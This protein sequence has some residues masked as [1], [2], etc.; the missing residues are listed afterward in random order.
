MFLSAEHIIRAYNLFFISYYVS[1]KKSSIHVQT[2][3]FYWIVFIIWW[4]DGIVLLEKYFP[5]T[6]KILDTTTSTNLKNRFNKTFVHFTYKIQTFSSH[7][8]FFNKRKRRVIIKYM[9][10][11]DVIR[12]SE[13]QYYFKL[14]RRNSYIN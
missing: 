6:A 8:L 14:Y 3:L 12:N 2:S 5:I 4:L 9:Y 10:I 11:Y 1:C 13:Q 7:R